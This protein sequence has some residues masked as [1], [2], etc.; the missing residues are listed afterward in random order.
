V[1]DVYDGCEVYVDG[2]EGSYSVVN[3]EGCRRGMR[4]DYRVN[5]QIVNHTPSV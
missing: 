2:L 5:S 1:Y 3:G 4:K